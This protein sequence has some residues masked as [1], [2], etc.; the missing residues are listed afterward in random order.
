MPDRTDDHVDVQNNLLT[1]PATQWQ[2]HDLGTAPCDGSPATTSSAG[3]WRRHHL[4][5]GVN[6]FVMRRR[7]DMNDVSQ[8]GMNTVAAAGRDRNVLGPKPIS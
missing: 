7:R 4:R 1:G 2:R 8:P 3:G 5:M 6:D